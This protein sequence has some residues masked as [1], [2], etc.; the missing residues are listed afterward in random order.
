M[1]A[2]FFHLLIGRSRREGLHNGC[3]VAVAPYISQFGAFLKITLILDY[4]DKKLL[5]GAEIRQQ[6]LFLFTF[7]FLSSMFLLKAS[8]FLKSAIQ[9]ISPPHIRYTKNEVFH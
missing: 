1:V 8:N 5:R 2:L 6:I 9:T 3:G 7:L 4:F